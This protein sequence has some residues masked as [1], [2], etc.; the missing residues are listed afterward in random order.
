MHGQP[1]CCARHDEWKEGT[2]S[3]WA[4]LVFSS[5][6]LSAEVTQ[7]LQSKNM[8]S[9]PSTLP[10]HDNDSSPQS[11]RICSLQMDLSAKIGSTAMDSMDSL[12]PEREFSSLQATRKV[13]FKVKSGDRFP[14]VSDD[15]FIP[16]ELY[17]VQFGNVSAK[18]LEADLLL[19]ASLCVLRQGSQMDA[20][21]QHEVHGECAVAL[22][23]SIEECHLRVSHIGLTQQFPQRS[24]VA[25]PNSDARSGLPM[26]HVD[27]PK[28]ITWS[29]V[30]TKNTLGVGRDRG[31]KGPW[32]VKSKPE[33]AVKSA[34]S[35]PESNSF[36]ALQCSEADTPSGISDGSEK[37]DVIDS[38]EPDL[39][40]SL[41]GVEVDMRTLTH[42]DLERESRGESP[43]KND[44]A[45]QAGS[46]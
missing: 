27:G 42:S 1:T 39:G 17:N 7:P 5:P 23:V 33:S 31:G 12:L 11:S 32:R 37:N 3:S 36:A 20:N 9:S 25:V 34:G 44:G 30:V 35:V 46:S 14:R 2:A 24:V 18:E 8:E 15:G 28:G 43:L 41:G 13:S 6:K 26:E 22:M 40:S 45:W 4:V 21:A 29:S 19:G 38:A 16:A 10:G